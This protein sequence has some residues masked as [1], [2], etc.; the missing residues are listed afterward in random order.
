VLANHIDGYLS[1]FRESQPYVQHAT[2]KRQRTEWESSDAAEPVRSDI[3]FDDENLIV[4]AENTQFRVYKGTLCGS[5]DILK[6]AIDNMGDSKG[7]E[8][9]PL[10]FLSDSAVEVAYLLRA[11]FYRW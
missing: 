2:H 1:R 7:V 4:Q 5:S 8:G 11:I 9:C 10:V 6:V 3:W